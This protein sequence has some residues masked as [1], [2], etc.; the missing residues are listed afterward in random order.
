MQWVTPGIGDAFGPVKQA[1]RETFL[2][3][4][5]QVLGEGTPGRG[6]KRLPVKQAGL[7]LP[8]PTNTVSD[9]WKASCVITGHLVTAL[10]GQEE[11]RTADQ[12][13]CLRVGRT[14]VRK[15]SVL[16]TEKALADNLL[17]EPVQGARRL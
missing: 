14:A 4:L 2:P 12:S 8:D 13:A 17:G 15:R 16:M 10:R 3:A 5:F 7:T 1:L 9:N 6:V 11:F